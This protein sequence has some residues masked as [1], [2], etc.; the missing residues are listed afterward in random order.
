VPRDVT[1]A[2][3]V[4]GSHDHGDHI[5]REAWPV[6]AQASPQA[7][8]GVPGILLPQLA[9]DLGME[10]SRFIGFDDGTVASVAGL[11]V[12]GIAAAHEFLDR[13]PLTGGIATSAS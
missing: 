8:F 6:I 4:L 12:R 13:D 2:T 7:R 9:I 10:V 1:N 11:E 3:L 5:D